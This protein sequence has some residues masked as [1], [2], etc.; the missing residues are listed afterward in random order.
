[1]K[2]NYS[3]M[4]AFRA[5]FLLV[6]L[7]GASN[8][9]AQPSFSHALVPDTIGLGSTSTLVFVIDNQ[10]SVLP[11]DQLAFVS[12]LLAMEISA[13]PNVN[14]FKPNSGAFFNIPFCAGDLTAPAGGFTITFQDGE[15]PALARCLIS[16]D[17]T[18]SFAGVGT[19]A[20]GT[21]TSSAGDTGGPPNVDL[22]IANDRPGITKSF[23]QPFALLGER[24]SMSFTIDN[25]LNL[26][27]LRNVQF[28][29]ELPPGLEIASPSN[30]S[31]DCGHPLVEPEITAEPGT[32]FLAYSTG[33]G[34]FGAPVLTA[35]ATCQVSVDLV[36]R[37]VGLLGNSTSELAWTRVNNVGGTSGHANAWMEGSTLPV[38]LVKE[39]LDDPVAPGDTVALEFTLTNYSRTDAATDIEFTD[40]LAATLAGLTAVGTPINACGGTL[41]GTTLLTLSGASLMSEESCSFSVDLV[42]PANAA[43]GNYVNITSEVTANTGGGRSTRSLS[44]ARDNLFVSLA[45]TVTKTWTDDPVGAG[46]TATL[47]FTV[48]NISDIFEATEIT[49]SD[50]FNSIMQTAV[51]TPAPGFCGVGS[52][53]TFFPL[54]VGSS[55]TRARVEFQDLSLA[56]GS[57]C[58]FQIVLDVHP[59]AYKGLIDNTTS[60]LTATVDGVSY[61]SAPASD[62]LA[63]IAAPLINK[64]FI[65]DPIGPGS[66]GTLEFTVSNDNRGQLD[67]DEW[68]D[69]TNVAL[70][71]NLD[72]ALTGMVAVGLPQNDVCGAGSMISGTDTVTLSGGSLPMQ[73]SC[74]F[75]VTVQVPADATPDSYTNQTSP[76]TAAASG[77]DV[78]GTMAT[79]DFEVEG[80]I[81]T[82]SFTDD[83]VEPGQQVT[84]EF[85]I[86]NASA[87]LSATGIV[88]TD[89]LD[90]VLDNLVATGLPA[91]D[92]C[93]AGSSLT[94]FDGGRNITFSGGSLGP[95][96]SCTFSVILDV[97]FSANPGSYANLT[98]M[99]RGVMD[100]GTR[101]FAPA[102]DVLEIGEPGVAMVEVNK[103]YTVPHPQGL[104]PEVLITLTCE[105]GASVAPNGG[106]DVLTV[107]GVAMFTVTGVTSKSIPCIAT[108]VV[109]DGYVQASS[110][111]DPV[112][113]V[114]NGNPPASCTITNR[115]AVTTITAGKTFSDG[116]PTLGVVVTPSCS[117]GT[118]ISSTVP[119]NA[120]ATEA[121]DV[122][123]TL[124]Y[125]APGSSCTFTESALT[126]YTQ[127]VGR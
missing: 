29:D 3:R 36:V 121:T 76:I 2:N 84:L 110:D 64:E 98:S 56:A 8:A 108:E 32:N 49:F 37:G 83:P 109:P 88:F 93:G 80:L 68:D 107:G 59:M 21:L 81:F 127:G 4:S 104:D 85:T 10:G 25:T 16:V 47:E 18:R 22:D 119:A 42:V 122:V 116:N 60:P 92:I 61:Q 126:G 111:C 95:N 113:A 77:V 89:D 41:S 125:F 75:G 39:F 102:S 101:F 103:A 26:N 9:F 35:G 38:H 11:V 19:V 105:G 17:V 20:T 87:S 124:E 13:F 50:E 100:G 114:P 112:L 115:P 117:A 30:F 23:S 67:D 31:T 74:T 118:L 40:D 1:M 34:G 72:A 45:P 120:T 27:D 12:D 69:Y 79:D 90:S 48:T 15:L 52:T 44:G 7:A 65:D 94:S 99:I 82:K 53:A 14:G 96:E 91:M 5:L 106:V 24:V 97:P 46:G 70:T 78:S 51:S 33:F 66:T 54:T 63:V 6:M 57:S 123:F 55:A 28:V 71:D 43:G 58:T 86:Q 62:D 73:T